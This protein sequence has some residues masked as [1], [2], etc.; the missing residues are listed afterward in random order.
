[1]KLRVKT[2]IVITKKHDHALVGMTRQVAE[3]LLNHSSGKKE[4]YT[5]YLPFPYPFVFL[6]LVGRCLAFPQSVDVLEDF[7]FASS[8]NRFVDADF[9]KSACFDYKGLLSKDAGFKSR[10]KFWTPEI[11]LRQ[12]HLF[13]FVITVLFPIYPSTFCCCVPAPFPSHNPYTFCKITL[14]ILCISRLVVF[15]SVSLSR[16]NIL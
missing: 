11:C 5:V 7:S 15:V 8:Y 2:V 16:P 6:F 12:P 13:D 9:E 4:P 14:Y 1:M 3:W 10:I